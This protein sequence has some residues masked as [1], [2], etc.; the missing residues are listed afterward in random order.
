[1]NFGNTGSG[2]TFDGGYATAFHRW[3]HQR[4]KYNTEIAV[5]PHGYPGALSQT[6]AALAARHRLVETNRRE[7][8]R[9]MPAILS[10]DPW[11]HSRPDMPKG[12]YPNATGETRF[13]WSSW[14]VAPT[15]CLVDISYVSWRFFEA[16]DFSTSVVAKL[17]PQSASVAGVTLAEK[18]IGA[19]LQAL[20]KWLDGIRPGPLEEALRSRIDK[21]VQPT[22]SPQPV[23]ASQPPPSPEAKS[24]PTVKLV[25][26]TIEFPKDRN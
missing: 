4:P 14:Q 16:G 9:N 19:F 25:E 18:E 24:E 21:P 7:A 5:S 26:V 12:Y 22:P 20:E 17:I 11:S 10:V 8:E 1:M 23:V 3:D 6:I 13:G 2:F 15:Q